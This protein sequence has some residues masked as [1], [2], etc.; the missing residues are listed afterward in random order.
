MIALLVNPEQAGHA[1]AGHPERPERVSAI[2]DAIKR[3]DLGLK[4]QLAR[5]APEALIDAVHEVSYVQRLDE[6]A[7]RGGGYLDPDT[8]MTAMSMLAA[9]T[10]GGA[11]VEGV[12]QVLAG[13]VS[14]AF[15][16]VR[17]PGHHAERAHAMGFCLLNNVAI[18]VAA[19]RA[20]GSSR[21]A[22]IDFDVHHGNGTQHTFED[23]ANLFY[24]STHQFPFYPGTGAASERGPNG[25]IHNLPLAAGSGDKEFLKAYEKTVGPALDAFGPEL[26]L[27]SAGFDAHQD[28]PLAGLEVTTDGYGELAAL[29]RGWAARHTTGRSVWML[30][31]GYDLPALGSS[32]VACLRALSAPDR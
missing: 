27:V 28:D 7:G 24:A 4:P 16:V 32:V 15:A 5:P 1:S 30:E 8:Y 9:R 31:G 19:A 17:P 22:I 29:I 3:A 26:I 23:D 10:A 20:Q 12:T 6:A 14:T 13:T 11:V 21:I 18:G 2:L 25:T